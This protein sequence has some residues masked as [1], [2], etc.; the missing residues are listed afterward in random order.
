MVVFEERIENG[1]LIYRRQEVQ[2]DCLRFQFVAWCAVG[3]DYAV[4]SLETCSVKVCQ[5][6]Q[7]TAFDADSFRQNVA[8]LLLLPKHDRQTDGQPTPEAN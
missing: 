5:V 1:G 6:L 4:E 2:N 7:F 8:F 3:K